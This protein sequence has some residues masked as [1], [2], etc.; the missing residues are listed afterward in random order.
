MDL[1]EIKELLKEASDEISSLQAELAEKTARAEEL[2]REN[3]VLRQ[4][5][6][7]QPVMKTANANDI[8]DIEASSQRGRPEDMLLQR[9]SEIG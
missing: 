3:A 1:K 5:L 8:G 4:K 2:E 7:E 6:S 9:L